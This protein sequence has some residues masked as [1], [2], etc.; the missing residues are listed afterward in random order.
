MPKPEAPSAVDA[1]QDQ[2]DS[3]A[4]R[5]VG[6]WASDST[7][8]GI[9]HAFDSNYKAWKRL[10]WVL[11]VIGSFAFMVQQ[12]VSLLTTFFSYQVE[13]NTRVEY[14]SSLPFP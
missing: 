13:T 4:V 8:H 14:P 5:V 10:L 6:E 1:A 7:I 3:S 11:L 12:I 2:K 9:N